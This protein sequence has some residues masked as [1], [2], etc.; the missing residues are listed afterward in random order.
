MTFA[1]GLRETPHSIL[2]YYTPWH[3]PG[4]MT[5]A[6]RQPKPAAKPSLALDLIQK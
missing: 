6:T 5:Q 4:H 3:L 2:I 1:L